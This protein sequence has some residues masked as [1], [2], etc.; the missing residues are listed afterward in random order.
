MEGET[1]VAEKRE[2]C[3]EEREISEGER[4]MS[5]SKATSESVGTSK[6]P[7][8]TLTKEDKFGKYHLLYGTPYICEWTPNGLPFY[9]TPD[10]FTEV[11]VSLPSVEMFL[12]QSNCSCPSLSFPLLGQPRDGNVYFHVYALLVSP[13]LLCYERFSFHPL[14]SFPSLF[15]V[16]S[17][18][19]TTQQQQ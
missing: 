11:K 8:R 6:S 3:G 10:T 17:L 7:L 19:T 18:N 1:L 9:V 5:E 15:F 4:E 16:S 13:S 12:L 14:F 2:I